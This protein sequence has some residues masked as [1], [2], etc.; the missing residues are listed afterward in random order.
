MNNKSKDNQQIHSGND[1]FDRMQESEPRRYGLL[2]YLLLI[3]VAA[4]LSGIY[5][6]LRRDGVMPMSHYIVNATFMVGVLYLAIWVFSLS[7]HE[8]LYDAAGYSIRK[9]YDLGKSAFRDKI[10][11]KYDS[12]RD[13]VR[14]KEKKRTGVRHHFLVVGSLFMLISL[15]TMYLT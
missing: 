15:V 1:Y 8:G 3:I 7:N 14:K 2:D 9:V 6:F 11:Y 4:V 5:F 10:I 12:F 13:Y